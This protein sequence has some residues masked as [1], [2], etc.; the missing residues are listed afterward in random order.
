MLVLA[1]QAT[2]Y[3]VPASNPERTDFYFNGFLFNASGKIVS[4]TGAC[5]NHTAFVTFDTCRSC[6]PC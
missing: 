4:R 6:I 5:T 2:P 1:V 3:M